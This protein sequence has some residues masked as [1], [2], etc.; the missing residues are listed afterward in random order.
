MVCT[1]LP[2]C[3]CSGEGDNCANITQQM[4]EAMATRQ[5]QPVTLTLLIHACS[6]VLPLQKLIHVRVINAKIML[7]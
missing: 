1:E 3:K 2:V 6:I 5:V 4:I 7:Y